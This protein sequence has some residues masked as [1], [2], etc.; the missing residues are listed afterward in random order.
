MKHLFDSSS[1]SCSRLVTRAYSTSFSKAITLLAPS[2]RP[3]IY[4]IYGFV[5]YADEIVDTFDGYNQEELLMEF[6]ENYEKALRRKISM[7]PILNAFQEIVHQ[8]RLYDLVHDF[9]ASMKMD[10]HKTEYNTVEEYKDYIYGSADVVG[11]M[12]LKVFVKGDEERFEELRPYAMRLGSAFQK[13]NFLRDYKDD[14]SGLG[15]SYFPN[16]INGQLDNEAKQEIIKD[17]EADFEA[18]YKGVIQL[19]LE[20]RLGV[21]LAYRYYKRLLQ[22]LKAADSKRIREER[23]RINNFLK[24]EILVESYLRYKLNAI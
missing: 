20:G 1:Y 23:I 7:N 19:P 13:V 22:E 3:A 2:V 11:L 15:R 14:A 8:Y 17:I 4:A 10:L 18:A 21:Y 6:E 12:C 16:L 9:L 24:L 5:R